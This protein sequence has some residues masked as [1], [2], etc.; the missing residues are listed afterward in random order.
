MKWRK[1]LPVE[2][3]SWER[4]GLL[5]SARSQIDAGTGDRFG[6]VAQKHVCSQTIIHVRPAIHIYS[7]LE[8]SNFKYEISEI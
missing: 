8:K 4:N 1:C 7:F 3:L 5:D 6:G 2:R